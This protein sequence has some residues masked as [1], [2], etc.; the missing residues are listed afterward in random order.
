M[1]GAEFVHKVIV[2]FLPQ[3]LVVDLKDG[4]VLKL[5]FYESGCLYKSVGE[6]I[7]MPPVFSIKLSRRF[8]ADLEKLI[9]FCFHFLGGY[10]GLERV[11][12]T[13]QVEVLRPQP[14]LLRLPAEDDVA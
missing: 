8:F 5:L 4:G 14:L 11:P 13:I 1:N 6:L 2:K 12:S 3:N 9:N 10:R 7:P